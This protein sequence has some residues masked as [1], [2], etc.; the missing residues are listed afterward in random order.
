VIAVVLNVRTLVAGAVTR[1]TVVTVD[2]VVAVD[3]LIAVRTGVVSRAE[4]LHLVLVLHCNKHM[5][6]I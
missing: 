2:V 3:A 1:H 5:S 6:T 4:T